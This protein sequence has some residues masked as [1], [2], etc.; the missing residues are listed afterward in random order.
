[1]S[2][3]TVTHPNFTGEARQA[4]EFYH[5]VFGGE[6]MIATFEQVGVPRD[7]P[8]SDTAVFA[9]VDAASPD[10]HHVAFGM[11][12]TD[13][14]RLAAYDVFAAADRPGATG[15]ASR[16]T[17]GLTHTESFFVLL[18]GDTLD[19][20]TDLWTK[21]ADDATV[22]QALAPASWAPAYGMLTDRFGITWVFGLAPPPDR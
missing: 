5:S 4:V 10:A 21:L 19:E 17:D 9:P 22:I 6:I 18:N 14:F 11:V 13:T 7:G 3:S 16:R 12:A 20:L 1:M 8:D 2:V 15:T